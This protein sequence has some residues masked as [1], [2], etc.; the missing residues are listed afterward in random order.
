[1]GKL[2]EKRIELSNPYPVK[3]KEIIDIVE[4]STRLVHT[5][6]DDK[7]IQLYIYSKGSERPE[8][9]AE[10]E[11]TS[12]GYIL[13]GADD[14]QG[15][16]LK[17]FENDL[18]DVVFHFDA[19]TFKRFGENKEQLFDSILNEADDTYKAKV[20]GKWLKGN[21][22][23]KDKKDADTFESKTEPTQ[24]I[25]QMKK[26]GKLNKN[27]KPTIMKEYVSNQTTNTF[28]RHGVE[29]YFHEYI[30]VVDDDWYTPCEFISEFGLEDSF[31]PEYVF[32]QVVIA[33]K[34][35]IKWLKNQGFQPDENG[36]DEAYNLWEMID[37][38]GSLNEN[39]M[40]N[41]NHLFE[42]KEFL[43][44]YLLEAVEDFPRNTRAMYR[45]A[46]RRHDDT[47]AIRKV[48]KQPYW[49]HPE[50]VAKIVMEHGGSDIE[51]KAAMAHDVLEDT[52]ESYE[53][54]VEKFGEKVASIV[55]E[56]TND[57][58]EIAKVGKEKY[59]SEELCR[60]SPE[61]LTVKLA[62]MLYNMKDSPTEKN[63]ERMRKNI[64]FLMMNRQLDGK[65]LELAQEIMEV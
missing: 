18:D 32:E 6:T 58:D 23:V 40:N 19:I 62:D 36:D 29:K 24:R 43:F 4:R 55:K 3:K 20:N 48:S 1:M 49:V 16:S 25:N 56:V 30:I 11:I 14:Y 42:S 21:K 22:L 50:G 60:L 57:K 39:T 51:I 28:M 26:D 8:A 12:V 15:N 10:V 17:E 53:D 5:A 27:A 33:V 47:G 46:K 7:T 65:H 44:E 54:M 34:S 45:F 61:A 63:Y 9:F 64:A 38:V 2:N 41:K 59:I 52:G 13:H 37:F 31:G 35:S